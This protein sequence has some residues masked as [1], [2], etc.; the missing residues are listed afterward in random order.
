V[1]HSSNKSHVWDETGVHCDFA[2]HAGQHSTDGLC[3]SYILKARAASAKGQP[4]PGVECPSLSAV[5]GL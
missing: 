3:C 4:Q 1:E 5:V 2:W